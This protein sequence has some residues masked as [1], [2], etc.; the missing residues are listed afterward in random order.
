MRAAVFLPRPWRGGMLR[1]VQGF[2]CE[3]LDAADRLGRDVEVVLSV[4]PNTYLDD[5]IVLTDPRLSLRETQWIL[6]TEDE[7]TLLGISK[8]ERGVLYVRPTD[9]G[10]D[11]MDCSHWV[12]FG[13]YFEPP[14]MLTPLRPYYAYAPDFIQRY[15]PQIY[16]DTVNWDSLAWKMN[17]A[18]LLTIRAADKVL[19][20]TPK[21]GEDA[22][23]YAGA[24]RENVILMPMWMNDFI[25]GEAPVDPGLSSPYVLWISNPAH[26]KNHLR[27]LAALE[28][29]YE[30]GG[31]LDFVLIGP[32]TDRLSPSWHRRPREIKDPYWMKVADK[33]ADTRRTRQRLK[34]FGEVSDE[35]Y[36]SLVS[37]AKFVWHNVLYDNGSF[38]ALESAR[39]GTPLLSSDYPQMRYI[40]ELFSIPASF[41]PPLEV[42]ETAEALLRMER[43]T[44][45]GRPDLHY[46]MPADWQ[47][48]IARSFDELLLSMHNS[49]C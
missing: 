13:A 25:R 32:L 38:V 18:L 41:F 27:A 48:W 47:E 10:R 3:L 23:G 26:H 22:V 43:M 40:C 19:V 42:E 20:T 30:M 34:F 17:T 44:G 46:R 7:L 5:E 4:L 35:R 31:N 29:Y 45:E 6:T 33:I 36:L 37:G 8:Q 2:C 9:G 11:F 49:S 14:G 15:V 21:T 39:L 1:A 16:G 12:I 28:R 24:A